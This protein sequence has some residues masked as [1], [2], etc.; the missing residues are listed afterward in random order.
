[1]N[2]GTDWRVDDLEGYNIEEQEKLQ[3]RET[4][5]KYSLPENDTAIV[6]HQPKAIAS[7]LFQGQA[8][9]R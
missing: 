7:N 9:C 4:P 2:A 1:M 8:K 3:A 5:F 6:I